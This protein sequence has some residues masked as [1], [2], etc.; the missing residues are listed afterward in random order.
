MIYRD[1][2]D[3]KMTA[4]CID[5][6]II[7]S[8]RSKDY[9]WLSNSYN[10]LGNLK[11]NLLEYKDA[12]I[13]VDSALRIAE[14][15][16]LP[17]QKGIAIASLARF[18]KDPAKSSGMRKK[19]VEILQ[20]I[21]GNEEEVSL[22]LINLGTHSRN[23]DT[24][25]HYY[26]DAI[27][28][29]ASANATEAEIAAYNNM[30]YSYMDKKDLLN[31][32]ACLIKFA[33]PLAKKNKNYD[34]LSTLDDSYSEV[35]SARHNPGQALEYERKALKA[36]AAADSEQA[37]GQIRLFAALLDVKNRELKIKT[38]EKEI[39]RKEN[40][41]H[42]M[43]FWFVLSI[44]VILVVIFLIVL[45]L[46]KNKIK[47]K[48]ELIMSAK[49]L[50]ESEEDLK[51]RVSMELHDVTIPFYTTM[52]QQ[53]EE[54]KIGDVKIEDELKN[55]LSKMHESIRQI[56]HRMNNSFLGQLTLNEHVTGLCKDLK[57]LTGI[58]IQCVIA[59]E[60]FNLTREE[61][62]HIY[63]IIQELLTNAIKYVTFGEIKLSL[64]NERGNF[65]I[66]YKDKGPGFDMNIAK[67]EGLGIMNIT[68]RAKIINGK[69]I[70]KTSP[71]KPTTWNIIIPLNREK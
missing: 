48:N 38:N 56:S 19:A 9:T 13:N 10:A 63:R 51:G 49:R 64:F 52:L 7:L 36:R 4:I 34:W 57:G 35:L 24:A 6:C 42:L 55:K 8:Q 37:S 60:D 31:A 22:I 25:I 32:E 2:A 66:I 16:N 67:N 23:S 5:S 69:A 47:Y 18:E 41:I 68:E 50:I 65:F 62:I 20:K 70:L 53:I 30:A 71:G 43:S 27:R 46:L 40:Q 61:T 21:P 1:A 26:Q 44:I 3:Y 12:Y 28:T 15:Y 29:A 11:Y 39:Q 33:V 59:D 45:K 54:A 14:E 58:P 17:K